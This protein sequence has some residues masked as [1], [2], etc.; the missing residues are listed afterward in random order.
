ME[1]YN[2]N[3]N[4]NNENESFFEEAQQNTLHIKDIIFEILR[5]LHWLVLFGFIGAFIAGYNVRKQERIYISSAQ[6]MLRTNNSKPVDGMVRES[7]LISEFSRSSGY[8][9]AS[10]I[11]NE[12]M[13][14]G[15]KTTMLEVVKRLNLNMIYKR[16]TKLIRRTNDLYRNTPVEVVLPDAREN[17]TLRMLVTPL[18]NDSVLISEFSNP[19]MQAVRSAY[20]DTVY[21]PEGR[22]IV[23]KTW[24]FNDGSIKNPV[25][26]KY[27]NTSYVADFYRSKLKVSRA[28]QSNT[29]INLSITDVSP[30][31]AADILNM[32]IVVYNEDA[33]NDKTKIIENT[34]DFINDRLASLDSDLGEKETEIAMFKKQHSLLNVKDYGQKYLQTSIESSEEMIRLEESKAIANYLLNYVKNNT[35]NK[36]LPILPEID[37]NIMQGVINQFNETVLK[38]EKY[39]TSG[40]SSNPVVN[41]LKESQEVLKVN[42]QTLIDAYI[43]GLDNKIAASQTKERKASIAMYQVPEK[44]LYLMGVERIQKIKETL[45]INLLT[46]REELLMSQ[47]QIEGNAK[48]I[49]EARVNNTPI[50]PDERKAILMGLVLGLAIPVSIYLLRKLLDTKVYYSQEIRKATSVPILCELPKYDKNDKKQIVVLENKRDKITEAF[51]LL[52]S[53]L[54]YMKDANDNNAKVLLFTSFGSGSGKTFVSMNLTTSLALSGKKVALVDL[55]IRKGTLAKRMNVKNVNGVTSL[56]TGRLNDVDDIIQKNVLV[57]GMDLIYSGPIP[58]NPAELLAS[59]RLDE[60]IKKLREIYDYV[61]LDSVPVGFIADVEIIKHLA[62]ATLFIIRSGNVDRRVL[63]ELD[64]LYI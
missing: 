16:Q 37:D 21:S 45:Y 19:S 60:M 27:Y 35:E 46:K 40:T 23:N 32:L 36:L 38:L 44:Q 22:I 48:I 33:I 6:I 15:S 61:I 55:D 17:Q 52:R 30:I 63:P 56:L 18:S 9:I 24:N 62:D 39:E 13:I 41:S 58:P 25:E 11:N 53:N 20:G 10:S 59:K 1:N 57:K 42:I 4:Q 47:P 8:V 28:S 43:A 26:V 50:A 64:R 3:N 2:I 34:Y 49:D 29:L 7:S 12:M 51:R 31:R 5:H 54:D 14:M